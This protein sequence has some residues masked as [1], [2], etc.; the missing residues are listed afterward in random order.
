M[1]RNYRQDNKQRRAAKRAWEKESR[2]KCGK[3]KVRRAKCCA[4]CA[5]ITTTS[6][7]ESRENAI[8]ALR[9]QGLLNTEIA[10]ALNSTPASIHTIVCRMRRN[11][12]VVPASTYHGDNRHA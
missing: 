4:E 12:R 6:A 11:G 8:L 10:T 3:E 5:S 7:K 2:C 9:A 1:S